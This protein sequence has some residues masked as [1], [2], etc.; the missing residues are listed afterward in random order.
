MLKAVVVR[1]TK[2]M[3]WTFN[4]ELIVRIQAAAEAKML[5]PSHLITTI[6]LEWLD[7][8]NL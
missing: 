8:N 4:P 3:G 6:L 1:K 5:K 7:R 2:Q